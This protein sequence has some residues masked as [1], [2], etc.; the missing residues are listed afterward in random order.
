MH[1]SKPKA[2]AHSTAAS[3]SRGRK[4][5]EDSV[6]TETNSS[7]TQQQPPQHE[8]DV[9]EEDWSQFVTAN[10]SAN[11]NASTQ[12]DGAEDSLHS[13]G[14]SNEERF[15]YYDT[16]LVPLSSS[17]SQRIPPDPEPS[18]P[19]LVMEI[20]CRESLTPLDMLDLSNGLSDATGHRIWMGAVLFLECMV[21]E[22]EFHVDVDLDSTTAEQAERRRKRRALVE[23]RTKLF[24]HKHVLELGSG[25]GA[26][27]IAIGLAGSRTRKPL[28]IT[29]TRSDEDEPGKNHHEE[30]EEEEHPCRPI[31]PL[32]LTLTDNEENV[33]ALCRNNCDRNLRHPE[34]ASPCV[35]YRVG[36]LDWGEFCSRSSSGSDL[37]ESTT[38]ASHEP[39]DAFFLDTDGLRGT[40]DTVVATD[41][42]YDV[43]AIPLLMTTAQGLLKTG[44]VFVL[45]HVPR[46][47]IECDLS[48]IRETLEELI[49]SQAR[50]KGFETCLCNTGK[51]DE[52]QNCRILFE[53]TTEDSNGGGAAAA[54][55]ILRPSTLSQVWAT[56]R[57]GEPLLSV[58][59]DYDYEELEACGASIL[60]FV[61][62]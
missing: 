1:S 11:G 56:P 25:T 59:S 27:L 40:L 31:R 21:R 47:S 51:G 19:P 8:D 53:G 33:L 36:K 3:V 2:S 57:Q 29:T 62:K 32:V 26:G 52:F 17:Q 45:A 60:F 7:A 38:P 30:E 54:T 14:I 50:Q 13:N 43:S 5:I 41:V 18:P 24:H 37:D 28:E 55:T 39:R 44:G 23:L 49:C 6:Q 58:S 48:K 16:V 46:A 10:V 9:I 20:R 22:L 12:T 35:D 34:Q 4:S 42:I 15:S 61:K